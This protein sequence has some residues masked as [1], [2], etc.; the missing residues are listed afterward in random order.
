MNDLQ[1]SL[2]FTYR[3]IT[4]PLEA[5][6]FFLFPKQSLQSINSFNRANGCSMLGQSIYHEPRPSL[7]F[8]GKLRGPSNPNGEIVYYIRPYFSS[9]YLVLSHLYHVRIVSLSSWEPKLVHYQFVLS[10]RCSY[11]F[12]LLRQS[13]IRRRYPCLI[14][15]KQFYMFRFPQ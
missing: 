12:T 2:I 7:S 1:F 3:E 4:I 5:Y 10:T 11:W 15:H 9:T 13:A 8:D 6:F 14:A